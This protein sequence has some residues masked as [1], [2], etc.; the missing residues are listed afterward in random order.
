MPL[1]EMYKILE[2]A[3]PQASARDSADT[4]ALRDQVEL[5]K[6]AIEQ[7][8]DA[9]QTVLGSAEDA[10]TLHVQLPPA[11]SFEDLSEAIDDLSFVVERTIEIQFPEAEAVIRSFVPGARWLV[12]SIEDHNALIALAQIFSLSAAYMEK[13]SRLKEREAPLIK[14]LPGEQQRQLIGMMEQSLPLLRRELAMQFDAA[15]EHLD[16]IAM[17]IEL[18]AKWFERGGD[19]LP[20]RLAPEEVKQ[21]F[22]QASQSLRAQRGA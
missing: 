2:R 1:H 15:K 3:L 8:M 5:L 18:S 20:S 14:D 16:D 22:A 6:A 21:A 7:T 17:A 12:V 11:Q 10:F 9:L 4:Q 13:K 19:F